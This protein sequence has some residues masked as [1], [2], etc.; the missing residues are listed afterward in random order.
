MTRLTKLR[1]MLD[2]NDMQETIAFYCD[3]LG[4]TLS[5]TFGHDPEKP[6]WC[7]VHR[8]DVAFMF[9]ASEPH[10][11]EDGSTHAHEPGLNGAL[12]VSVDDVDALH[13]EVAERLDPSAIV[14]PPTDQ[15]HAMRE[16]AIHDPNGFALVFGMPIDA[17][18]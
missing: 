3:K 4:F 6:T 9:T 2:V 16:F 13:A 5:A 7:N 12:Y 18:A 17:P 11:H 10:E 8:D 1:T 15:P 14:Y